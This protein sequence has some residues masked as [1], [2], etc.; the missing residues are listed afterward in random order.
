MAATTVFS[1]IDK[2]LLESKLRGGI[3]HTNSISM[4]TLIMLVS[5]LISI[6][7]EGK[8]IVPKEVGSKRKK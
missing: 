3:F 4:F 5:C 2:L 6:T 1:T 7:N 8:T